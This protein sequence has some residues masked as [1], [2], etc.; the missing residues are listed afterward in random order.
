MYKANFY[1]T[2]TNNIIIQHWNYSPASLNNLA[3]NF[4]AMK[5]SVTR[6]SYEN[7]K[8]LLEKKEIGPR[9]EPTTFCMAS[10]DANHYTRPAR[11]NYWSKILVW[12]YN[13]HKRMRRSQ[14]HA[15]SRPCAPITNA[16]ANHIHVRQLHPPSLAW[17][18]VLP[19][20]FVLCLKQN[21]MNCRL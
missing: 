20:I 4:I 13:D 3:I 10:Y 5:S 21:A 6:C 19:F 2:G 17:S 9:F 14:T 1:F 11:W 16:C 18:T 12:I 7:L 15:Q 8:S